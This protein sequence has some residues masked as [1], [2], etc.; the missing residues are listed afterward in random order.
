[1]GEKRRTAVIT[2][3]GVVSPIGVGIEA[4][5]A[6][7]LAGKSGV[8]KITLF[9]AS[10]FPCDMAA[11]V[12]DFRTGDFFEEKE[13]RIYSRGSQFAVAAFKMA[14]AD[15]GLESFDSPNTDVI[16]GAA[17]LDFGAIEREVLESSSKL[18][19]F[20]PAMEFVGLMQ[21]IISIP[22]NLISKYAGAGGYVTTNSA[23]CS[24]G[25]DALNTAAERIE[26]GSCHTC[27]A[28]G[29]DTPVARLVLNS[30]CIAKALCTEKGKDPETVI[31]PFDRF[32]TKSVLGEG[33][34]ILILEEKKRAL[35]RGARVYCEFRPGIQT[36]E[37]NNFVLGS[38]KTGERW[39]ETIRRTLRKGRLKT[40]DVIN[41]HAPSDWSQDWLEAQIFM[42]IWGKKL[43][44]IPITSIKGNWPGAMAPTGA[45]QAAIAAKSIY[46]QKIP[47]IVNHEIPEERMAGMNFVKVPLKKRI[48]SVLISAHGIGGFNTAAICH[49][50]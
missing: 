38:Q 25:L 14:K 15:S 39:E 37:N 31:R 24:S 19:E 32:R 47:P 13:G 35:A 12:R 45:F 3:I 34:T 36:S 22:A 27:I 17:Q 9:D 20:N 8:G 10:S 41:A 50:G 2:G 21:T 42:R 1:M 49:Q 26:N 7:C 29:V 30:F 16:I 43:S 23:A 33:A 28:G 18:T 44:R 6:N 40:P 48:R 11:E 4:A 5:W 46:E